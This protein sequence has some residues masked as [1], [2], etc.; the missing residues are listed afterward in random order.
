MAAAERAVAELELGDVGEHLAVPD[1]QGRRTAAEVVAARHHAVGRDADVRVEL[2]DERE[3]V[4]DGIAGQREPRRLEAGPCVFRRTRSG[5][6]VGRQVEPRERQRTVDRGALAEPDRKRARGHVAVHLEHG[7]LECEHALLPLE[8]AAGPE[9]LQAGAGRP[10]RAQPTRQL[11]EARAADVGDVGGELQAIR[12]ADPAVEGRLH[13]GSGDRRLERRAPVARIYGEVE[14]GVEGQLLPAQV[15]A[16]DRRHR[17]AADRREVGGNFAQH[18]AGTRACVQDE[19]AA[20]DLERVEPELRQ[21]AQDRRDLG[22]GARARGRTS[23]APR[24]H[25]QQRVFEHQLGAAALDQRERLLG[26]ARLAPAARRQRQRAMLEHHARARGELDRR[27][28]LI[29]VAGSGEHDGGAQRQIVPEERGD[30]RNRESQRHD[31]ERAS[32]NDGAS[33]PLMAS[34][35]QPAASPWRRSSA[36]PRPRSS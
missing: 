24:I 12:E 13:Q 34:L 30:Q 4:I 7:L 25:R 18:L 31:R 11:P 14:D 32:D 28:H 10:R 17:R 22:G 5:R 27:R 23:A 16:A 26:A 6:Q 29:V 33:R 21:R 3:R 9:V 2:L 1:R 36:S 20:A 15:E 19:R 8:L 35:H